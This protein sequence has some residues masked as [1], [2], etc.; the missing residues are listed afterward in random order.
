ME[1]SLENL[2]VYI[3]A[4]RVKLIFGGQKPCTRIF[5][6]ISRSF[7]HL[8]R[9]YKCNKLYEIHVTP[10]ERFL[11]EPKEINNFKFHRNWED[12][13]KIVLWKIS[14]CEIWNFWN[15]F[16]WAPERTVFGRIS[17]NLLKRV[18]KNAVWLKL[19]CYKFFVH[20]KQ[21]YSISLWIPS[22]YHKWIKLTIT[23]QRVVLQFYGNIFVLGF[24]VLL[25]ALWSETWK[26]RRVSKSC[27][28]E[29]TQEA[30]K[31][32]DLFRCERCL[33]ISDTGSS[34]EKIWLKYSKTYDLL[35]TS[36]EKLYHWAST[37]D[38]CGS[39]GH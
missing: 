33:L 22:W 16:S 14:C 18:K 21:K 3:G 5:K 39:F 8:S 17:H 25:W 30:E 32:T 34:K 35:V 15:L 6:A 28:K 12:T 9:S 1:V 29:V 10:K 23:M 24:T 36:P 13:G 2:F 31:G 26:H 38:T 4:W 37:Q 19:F 7:L 27:Y 11:W 20:W